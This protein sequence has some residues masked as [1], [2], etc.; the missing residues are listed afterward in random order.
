MAGTVYIV[1]AGPGDPGL[2]TLRAYRLLQQTDAVVY[3]RLVNSE[4]IA[5]IAPGVIRVFAGKSCNRHSMTQEEINHTL[6]ALARKKKHVVRLKGGDPFIFGRGGEE[7]E[8][9]AQHGIAFEIVPGI[10][11][12]AGCAAYAGIPLTHRQLA[13]GVRYVTGHRQNDDKLALNWA[14]M[15]DADTT[16][17]I[18]MGLGNADTIRR[19]LISHGMDA[20]TPVAVICEGTTPHQRRHITTLGQLVQTI[21]RER[22]EPPATIIIGRVVALAG[23][24]DWFGMDTLPVRKAL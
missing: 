15:A 21:A 16:L 7:A 22:I 10:S 12:A 23:T 11:A 3:D 19:E 4:V 8:F 9:L 5:L 17:V 2:L 14:S 18:Y 1:G 20:S 13:S 24:M 6:L